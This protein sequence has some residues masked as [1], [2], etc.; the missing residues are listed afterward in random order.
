VEYDVT[1]SCQLP[2]GVTEL[3]SAAGHAR[4]CAK[5]R[6]EV[7][8]DRLERLSLQVAGYPGKEDLPLS[9]SLAYQFCTLKWADLRPYPWPG[10]LPLY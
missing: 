6:A 7:S 4:L 3:D 2:A 9:L 8:T 5:Q 10:Q 1:G